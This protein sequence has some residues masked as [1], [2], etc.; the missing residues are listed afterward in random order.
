LKYT[1]GYFTGIQKHKLYYQAWRPEEPKAIIIVCHGLGEH[2][3][4]YIF[5]AKHFSKKDLAF[6]AYDH[7]GHGK[8]QGKRGHV[9]NFVDYVKDLHSFIRLVRRK[10]GDKKYFL[11]GHSLGALIVLV[12]LM[13]GYDNRISGSIL[14]APPLELIK[15][16]PAYKRAVGNQLS[17][18][19][20]TLSFFNEID[21]TLLSHD[22]KIVTSYMN[23][24]LVYRRVSVKF[25][26]EFI[27]VVNC[28]KLKPHL[29][30]V[31]VLIVHG[32]SDRICDYQGSQK[33]YEG[34]TYPDK[35][36]IQYPEFYHEVMNEVKRN[37]VFR[38]FDEWLSP[39]I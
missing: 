11:L 13:H 33:F 14:S 20:P 3:G 10:E 4:R 18:I 32:G 7:R 38:D 22:L 24:P 16:I 6:Y 31:P 35:S 36:F 28:V 21:P 12:Y 29:I 8:S 27:R 1:E 39:R 30:K 19:F 15:S 23:D 26:R 2:S 25:L 37:K 9:D 5:P 34:M 17:K